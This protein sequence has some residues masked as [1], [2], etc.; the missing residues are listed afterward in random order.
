MTPAARVAAAIDI[1]DDIF[2][3]TAAEKAISGWGRAHRFAGSKDRS[4]IRDHVFQA[5]RC[6]AS[7][8]WIGGD[9]T[10]RGV[11]LGAMRASDEVDQVF[12]GEGYAPAAVE[13]G[14]V[15]QPLADADRATQLD[16]PDWL[17][18]LF[19]D[20]LGQQADDV[21]TLMQ[22]R[23]GVFLRVNAAVTDRET[24]QAQL[25]Q[26]DVSTIPVPDVKNALQV[27]ENERR[28]ANSAAYLNGFVELQDPSS[29]QAV[30]ALMI[31][32][33]ST[34]LDYCAG[35][36]GKALA[37]AAS[38]ATVTAHDIDPR[39][40]KDIQ[41]RAQRAGVEIDIV[42][43][44]NL[45]ALDPFDMVFCDAPCS[46]SGTWRR[47]P[48]A[49]WALT[50]DRLNELVDIQ[51]SVLNDASRFVKTGGRLVYATC[52]VFD[53]ENSNQIAAFIDQS[54]DFLCESQTKIT[55]SAVSDGF[56]F[57]VLRRI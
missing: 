33:R 2:T 43:T 26:D 21:L 11:M 55:P 22:N 53:V 46:G 57:A 13:S 19:D 52:S 28:V 34:V 44:E 54:N 51:R 48:Q 45:N 30:N 35:G 12:T 42:L 15:G 49:K 9:D 50:Q 7:Y 56:F 18:P 37:L 25:A 38:G 23:A 32:P 31:E 16:T 4:A 14:E 27:T 10:G 41:P 8:A 36:G 20:A 47:A 40:T 1:L 29:Q 5:L 3:G 17:L 6:R 24:A 39:R